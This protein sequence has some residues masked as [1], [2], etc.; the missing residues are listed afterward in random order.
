MRAPKVMG[1]P[2]K[3]EIWL[4]RGGAPPA[5][6]AKVTVLEDEIDLDLDKPSSTKQPWWTSFTEAVRV[7]LAAQIDLGTQAP[8]DIDTIYV[9]GIG[10]GDPGPLLAAQA[11]SGRLGIVPPGSATNTVNGEAALSTGGV[12]DWRRLVPLGPAA[13]PGTVAV[14]TALAGA[15]LLRGLIG[16]E[17]DHRPVNRALVGALWPALWG[18]SLANV[19]GVDSAADELGLWA[20]DNLV[21]EGPLPSLRIENQPYGV[22]PATSLRRWQSTAGDPAIEARLVPLV[23]GLVDTW[24][25]AALDGADDAGAR[26]LVPLQPTR[27]RGRAGYLVDEAGTADASPR[28]G[29]DAGAAARFRRVE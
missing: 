28:S 22:L 10:G 14:S 17:P 8:D 16:G 26:T 23:R 24:A 4:A 3:M 2:P 15:P 29:G 20:A 13:Q 7:G 21:P 9:V 6:V 27:R 18:H 11:D 19:W 12:D 25:A 1:L 5:Q